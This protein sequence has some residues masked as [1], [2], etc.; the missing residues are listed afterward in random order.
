MRPNLALAVIATAQLM[1]VLDVT[2]VNIALPHMRTAL[3]F[4]PTGLAWVLNAYTLVF[5]GLLLLGGRAGD[6]FGRRRMFIVGVLIFALAS[7]LGGFAWDKGW[8]LAMRA[9]QG[10][11]GAIASPT[12]LA[13][14]TTTFEEGP[15]R[16]RAFGVYAAVS[17]AGAAIGLILGGVLVQTLSWRWVLFVNAPIGVALAIVTPLVL[18]ES[19]RGGGRLAIADAVT[20]T[21]GMAALVY[22]FIN[23]AKFGWYDATT[24]GSLAI[25]VV[26]LT[27]FVAIEA[28]SAQ[29][30]MPLRLFSD[31]NRVGTY[32]VMLVTGAGVFAMFYFLTQ[33]IQ[34]VL[35]FSALAAG[36]A[37]LPVSA[38]I[39][40]VAQIVSRL[41]TRVPARLLIANGSAFAGAGLLWMSTLTPHSSYATHVLPCLLLVAIGMGFVFVPITLAAVA[42]VARE[43]AGIASAM[44]NVVQQVGGTIGLSALVTIFGTASRNFAASHGVDVAS[45]AAF[46]HGSDM[47]FRA[48]AVFSAVGI[49]AALMLIRVRPND[50]V[51][52]PAP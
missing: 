29:P 33:Y 10:V 40:T 21:G 34:G 22:G 37:F 23:A 25:A 19:P 46:T 49:V 1:V 14:V 38:T 18:A 41:V 7:L 4:S 20:S 31:R 36:F 6:L 24:L 13:L 35:G 47:A 11:G 2:I 27:V 42:G 15:E 12:A 48:G 28:G 17:G 26:L 3:H 50:G 51:A 39:V 9:L 43:D 52:Q 30:L 44:L 8:L 32:L 45:Q 16:N 5:G